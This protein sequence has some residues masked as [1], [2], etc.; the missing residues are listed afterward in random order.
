MIWVGH[1]CLPGPAA[2]HCASCAALPAAVLVP[3]WIHTP[4]AIWLSPYYTCACHAANWRHVLPYIPYVGVVYDSHGSSPFCPGEPKQ[5]P[6]HAGHT[7]LV[8]PANWFK[9][10][11]EHF[12]LTSTLPSPAT[13]RWFWRSERREAWRWWTVHVMESLETFW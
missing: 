9:H 12:L 7:R 13:F 4:G 5:S 10:V 2:R 3:G 6:S 1:A 8:V 11:G